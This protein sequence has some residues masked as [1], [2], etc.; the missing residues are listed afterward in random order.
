M[1]TFLALAS[2]SDYNGKNIEQ[3]EKNMEEVEEKVKGV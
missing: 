1:T 3:V 2:T